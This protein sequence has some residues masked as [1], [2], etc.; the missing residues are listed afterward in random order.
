MLGRVCKALL[1]FI[2]LNDVNVRQLLSQALNLG[3]IVTTA[4]MLWKGL[5]FFTGSESPVVVV[6]SG[7][8]EPAFYK[9]DILFLNMGRK[10]FRV[11]EVVVFNLEGR[12]IPIVHRIIKVH[13]P[14]KSEDILILTKGDKNFE[15]DRVLYNDGQK[16]LH[17]GDL[18]GRVRGYLP[19]FGWA[20]I[21]MNE[22]PK[23]KYALI[24]IMA[25]FA[26]T[27]RESL[28]IT[29]WLGLCVAANCMTP[30]WLTHTPPL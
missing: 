24:G 2:G 13:E 11:G 3:L 30:I 14:K 29:R 6:L 7:S 20:T 10:P 5:V 18:V 17:G 1:T 4:L 21:I 27:G 15:D 16:W 9:G 25:I 23:V 28:R 22:Y 19:Y 12:D 8:M 26:L